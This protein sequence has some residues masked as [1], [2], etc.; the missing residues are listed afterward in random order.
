MV[1]AGIGPILSSDWGS[2]RPAELTV[3]L[4]SPELETDWTSVF[5]DLE[6]KRPH[7]LMRENVGKLQTEILQSIASK[8]LEGDR[9]AN[10]ASGEKN[11]F[12]NIAHERYMRKGQKEVVMEALPR[13][14]VV[15]DFRIYP[16]EIHVDPRGALPR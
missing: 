7:S 1:V 4:T 10:I 12:G 9:I 13:Q 5:D 16:P 3:R 14:G 6:L 15:I 2:Y 8:A 11:V